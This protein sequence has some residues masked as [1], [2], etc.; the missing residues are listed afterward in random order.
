M[1]EKNV[2]E[3]MRS[4]MNG[5]E[6]NRQGGARHQGAGVVDQRGGAG[7]T[8]EGHHLQG[9]AGR[10]G[11]EQGD[12]VVEHLA[13]ADRT[14]G[15]AVLL[16]QGRAGDHGPTELIGSGGDGLIRTARGPMEESTHAAASADLQQV[17]GDACNGPGE[18]AL[19][20]G[21]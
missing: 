3:A 21:R 14:S 5:A 7:A 16:P 15:A 10:G 19:P 8:G 9:R 17:N 20:A 6:S 18:L 1:C 2:R 4:G 12:G 11:G 13:V